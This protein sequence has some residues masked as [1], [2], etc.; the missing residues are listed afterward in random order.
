MSMSSPLELEILPLSYQKMGARITHLCP[1]ENCPTIS[2]AS[3]TVLFMKQNGR[4]MFFLRKKQRLL[5]CLALKT[6]LLAQGSILPV[7]IMTAVVI[8]I[9][10]SCMWAIDLCLVQ[11][12]V[13]ETLLPSSSHSRDN[14][15][16]S[17]CAGHVHR[18]LRL[19]GHR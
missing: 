7:F 2:P 15:A 13:P 3:R 4:G 19:S 9:I 10:P 11:C 18:A 16:R 14:T 12:W 5:P 6:A 1:A 17:S 8:L